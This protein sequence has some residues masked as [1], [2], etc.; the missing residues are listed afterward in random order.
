[1]NWDNLHQI[2]RTLYDDMMP[3]CEDM[4]GIAKGIAG[5]GALFY[6]AH[7]VWQALSRAEPIDIYPLL[8]PFTIGLCIM[9]FPT[10]VLGTINTVMSPV[11]T[12]C[13]QIWQ[14]QTLNLAELKEK[15]DKLEYE[16][17]VREGKAWLVDNEEFDRK[18]SKM[19]ILNPKTLSMYG[20]R[21]GYKFK[22][23][24]REAIR[25]LLELLFNAA[26][27]V[28]DVIRTFFLVV[29]SILGPL[30]FALS[31]YDGFQS[32]LTQWIARYISIYLWLPVSDLFSAILSRIQVLMMDK[33]IAELN[34]PDFIP[35]SSDGVFIIFMLIGIVG[36][37]TIP[38]VAG[39]IIQSGG[40]GGATGTMNKAGALAGGVAGAVAG[41]AA[42]R[43]GTL[44]KK[45]AGAV[46][47]LF[48]K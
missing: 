13:N 7:R 32:T 39:W 5:L 2:L 33:S 40:A 4:T 29:L 10:V 16:A 6:I 30:A 28:I 20:E 22:Q 12:G 15:R 27:L 36:Y 34:D 11:V 14:N 45:G 44:A 18:L 43:A 47:G 42:G 24:L 19:S 31:V 23:G 3:L 46:R 25:E 37:F 38:T 17:R 35:D 8:R 1:M 48:K 26:A 9:L 41:N 21:M